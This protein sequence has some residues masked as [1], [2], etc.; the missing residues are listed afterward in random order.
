M[1]GVSG[2][3][4]CGPL[5]GHTTTPVRAHIA[6]LARRSEGRG[7]TDRT[8]Y[9]GTR[10]STKSFYVHHSQMMVKAAVM[11]DAKAILK[12]VTCLKQRACIAANA[13]D[14]GARA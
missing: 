11:H 10:I 8:K 12:Q 1:C 3:R 7:A 14:G 2:P 13:A 4:S 9:G 5:P 6:K